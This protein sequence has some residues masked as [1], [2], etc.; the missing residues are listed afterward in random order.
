MG[1]F[2]ETQIGADRPGSATVQR[3]AMVQVKTFAGAGD[4]TFYYFT[5]GL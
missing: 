1:D 4:T 2:V 3:S 5:S